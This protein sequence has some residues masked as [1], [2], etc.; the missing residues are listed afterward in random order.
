[1]A[2]VTIYVDE[3]TEQL[4]RTAAQSAGLSL[5]RWV[6]LTIRDRVAREWPADVIELAGAWADFPS[7]EEL[8]SSAGEDVPR[9]SL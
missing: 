1:M 9:E 7:A 8:R 4:A 6:V 2:Q 3:R 5:S